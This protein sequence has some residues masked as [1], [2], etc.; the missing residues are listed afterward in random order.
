MGIFKAYDIRGIY[1]E[2]IDADKANRI[3]K[4]IVT[5]LNADTIVVGR[6]NRLSSEE[7]NLNLARPWC[8]TDHWR[9]KPPS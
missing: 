2:E 3:A 9:V 6:D 4:A 8:Q 5:F 1:P 7:S